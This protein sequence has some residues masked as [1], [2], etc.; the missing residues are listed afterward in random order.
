MALVLEIAFLTGLC[1]AARAPEETVPDWPPQPDRIFSALV[2]SWGLR[3]EAA[4]E[5][6]ALEWLERQPPP[7]IVASDATPRMAPQVFVPPN[8]PRLDRKKTARQVWPEFRARQARRF[9]AAR[10]EDPLMRLVWRT[11]APDADILGPLQR[12]AESTSY[13]GHSASLC[14][15]RFYVMEEGALQQNEEHFRVPRRWVYPGRLA[16]LKREYEAGR[17]PGRGVPVRAFPWPGKEGGPKT[18]FDSRWLILEHVRGDRPDIRACALL[19]KRIRDTLMAGYGRI[20][21]EVPAI[22]SGHEPDGTP[23]KSTHIAIIPLAFIGFPHADGRLFGF[24]VVPPAGH[25]FSN[26]RVFHKV[27]RACAPYDPSLLRHVME[28]GI[29]DGR[30]AS[31]KIGL[32]PS[33][34]PPA[35]RAS[36][37][38]RHYEG[39]ARFFATATPILLDRHLKKRGKERVEEAIAL[40]KLACRNIGLPDPSD[41]QVNKHPAIEGVPSAAPSGSAPHWTRWRLPETLASR[42]LV[43]AVIAFEEPVK[44]PVI[45]GAGRFV[46]L[47]LCRPIREVEE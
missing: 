20:G 30:R 34:E 35:G 41:V 32:A 5:R 22:I 42:Q 10:P 27:L 31:W 23:L 4:D 9:P 13:I 43:H 25:V 28:V 46:G 7:V 17:R 12:L 24:A 38:P 1:R 16:E 40:V 14:R 44:G 26:D 18:V 6:A 36:L 3:G 45:L 8:D 47:G 37:D 21:R 39:P 33:F 19:A 2:A 11:N 15:C 29:K